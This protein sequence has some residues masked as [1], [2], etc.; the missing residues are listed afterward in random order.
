VTDGNLECEGT[1]IDL[2]RLLGKKR[3]KESAVKREKG[4]EFPMV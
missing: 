2:E 3:T 1:I 4:S